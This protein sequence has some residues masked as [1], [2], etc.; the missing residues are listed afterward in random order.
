VQES[1]PIRRAPSLQAC[2][3]K[4]PQLM[5]AL[6]DCSLRGL[7]DTTRNHVVELTGWHWTTLEALLPSTPIGNYR[8]ITS[9]QLYDLLKLIDEM[10]SEFK[11]AG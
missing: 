3:E 4:R 11:P 8:S 9:K 10:D 1:A 6:R 5:Q 7:R 2:V